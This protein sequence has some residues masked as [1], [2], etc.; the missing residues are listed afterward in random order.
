MTINVLVNGA[1]GRMGQSTLKAL[2]EHG[3]FNVV[4]ETGR[5]YDLKKAGFI[6]K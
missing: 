2:A 6:R 1:F 5:E 4:G 3:G